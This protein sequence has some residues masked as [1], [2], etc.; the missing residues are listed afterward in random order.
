MITLH[1]NDTT[2]DINEDD[3]S[4]RYRALKSKPQLVLKFSLPKFIE[5]P[6]GTWCEYQNEKYYLKY[7][8]NLKKNGTR[9]IEYTMTMGTDVDNLSDYKMRNSVD[10]RLKWS[11]CAKPSEFIKEIVAE[12]NAKEGNGVWSVGECIDS[13]EKTVEFNHQYIFDALTSIAEAFSTEWEIVGHTISLHKVEYFKDDP[14]P[15]AYGKGNGFV[16][17]VGRATPSNEKP[18][19]RLYVQGGDRNID[20]SKYGSSELLLPKSQTYEYEGRTYKTDADGYYI[21]RNDKVS[22]Y[23]KEDSLDLSD[24]YPSRVG[25]VSS[26]EVKNAD[27]HFYDIID[28]TIPDSLNYS[29]C[30]IE[31]E[32]PT[33]IFQSGMLAGDG[34]EFEFT[35]NHKEKRFEIVPQEIDGITMPNETYKPVAGDKYAVFGIM[36]PDS[37]I[38]D[39]DTQSGA[40]WDMFK[41]GVKYLYE[42]EEQK[43]T[44]TGTLQGLWSKKNWLNIGGRMKVG[45]YILFKDDQFATEGVK[46]RITGIKDFT[47]KPYSPTIEIS[48]S[49]SGSSV[50]SSL[51]KIDATEVTI[52]DT[53]RDV[54]SFTKRRFR[55]ARETA[56]MLQDALLNYGAS[57]NPITVQTMQALVGD[58]SLQFDYIESVSKPSN[59]IGYPFRWDNENKQLTS[60]SCG[61][62]HYT[63]GVSD[64]TPTHENSEYKKWKLSALSSAKLTDATKRYYLYLKCPYNVTWD[65]NNIASANAEPILSE[66]AIG[67]QP[68]GENNYYFLAGIL[69]SEYEGERSFAPMNGFTEITPGQIVLDRILSKNGKSFWD[70]VNNAFHIGNDV[71]YLDFNTSNDGKLILNGTLVQR[72]GVQQPI[73]MYRGQWSSS[74]AYAV[75][76][77]VFYQDSDKKISSYICIKATTAGIAPTNTEYWEPFA[78]GVRGYQGYASFKSTAFIRLPDSVTSVN[79]PTGGNYS[80]PLPTSTVTY[81]GKTY[82]WSDGI[83]DGEYVL[84][85]TTRIF[86]TDASKQDAA[87]STPRKMTDTSEFDVCYHAASSLTPS[88]PTSHYTGTADSD[89]GNGWHNN[90]NTDDEWMAT[91]VKTNGEW[92]TWD[93]TKIKG[94]KGDSITGDTGSYYL[95]LYKLDTSTPSKPTYTNYPFVTTSS[96]WQTQAP[97]GVDSTHFIYMSYALLNPNTNTFGSWSTPIRISGANGE[98]GK[99]GSDIEFI[100]CRTSV[101]SCPSPSNAST[102]DD[103][104]PKESVTNSDLGWKDNPSGVTETYQYEFVSVRIKEK[105]AT[106]WG[107]FST[108]ALWSKWG[109]KGMDGD[110]VEYIFQRTEFNIKPSTP[111]STNTNGYVPNGW[112]N[113]PT[114]VDAS[115]PYEWVSIRRKSNE[116]WQSF[117]TPTLWRTYEHWNP[118]LL[119]QTEFENS[120]RMNKWETKSSYAG[121]GAD[122]S[123]THIV[124]G[125]I[126]GRNYYADINIKRSSES[127]YK[128]ILRQLL[129]NGNDVLKLQPATWYT[130]SFYE[131]CGA[132]SLFI[133]QTSSAYGFAQ[134]KLYLFAGHT[135]SLHIGGYVSQTAHDKGKYLAVFIYNSGWSKSWSVTTNETSIKEMTLTISDVPTTGEYFMQAYLYPNDDD[136][137]SVDYGTAT[138]SWVRLHDL[139]QQAAVYIYPSAV[140]TSTQGYIDGSKVSFGVDMQ[141]NIKGDQYNEGSD[142]QKWRQHIITFKTK[143]KSKNSDPDF[144]ANELLLFRLLPTAITGQKSF[145]QIC[146]PKLEVGKIATS[147]SPNTQDM[148][149][150]YQE[151]RFAKNGSTSTAPDLT[152]TASEPSGWSTVQPTLGKLEYLWMTVA[153]KYA[154]GT[155]LENWSDPVR[156]TPYDGTDGKSPAM[157]YRGIYDSAKLYYGTQYR[158]DVV[159]YQNT[160]YVARVDAGE[161]SAVTPT[162][163]TKWNT[164]GAQFESVATELLLAELANIAG[165][166]FKD[167]QLISQFG[168]IN[169]DET[170]EYDDDDF[171]PAIWLD[172]IHGEVHAGKSLRLDKDG[173][174]LF[175]SNGIMVAKIMNTTISNQIDTSPSNVSKTYANTTTDNSV[176]LPTSTYMYQNTAIVQQTVSLGYLYQNSTITI[177]AATMS[178]T[179]PTNIQGNSITYTTGYLRI[180]LWCGGRQIKQWQVSG[181]TAAAVSGTVTANTTLT[182]DGSTIPEGNYYIL[183]KIYRNYFSTG[184]GTSGGTSSKFSFSVSNAYYAY[185]RSVDK[186]FIIGNNG[187]FNRWSDTNYM[188]SSTTGHLF[189]YGNYVLRIMSSGIQKSTDGGSTWTSL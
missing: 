50:G 49:V 163:T 107:N 110:G 151:M 48:N 37:Y 31:G 101:N 150:E 40:S 18:I 116:V 7:P 127:S 160:Y 161:F 125:G 172:G 187:M 141:T 62:M 1:Y 95:F 117:S 139:T 185:R 11:M 164:F 51:N 78:Q 109:E 55:D 74:V 114:G 54:L 5:F 144:A 183:Y 128:E 89:Q 28:N 58:E 21:E 178:A 34:K 64:L 145:L 9:D 69:S 39:N 108:P 158:V 47:T 120:D 153:K 123:Y 169:G 72:G 104:V 84:W 186:K 112:T 17:G 79:A 44:F 23:T 60:D 30:I 174:S 88:N 132:S 182:V 76:D 16:P 22:D 71:N 45:S 162:S 82:S 103:Y 130:L 35:Y 46:I 137:S 157:V 70:M 15:L 134:Q 165:W 136:R 43:F 142:N 189:R 154:D 94:E 121:G 147:Y 155:L 99:D 156:V 8:E 122:D 36:L 184:G 173:I 59:V 100:Y 12:L 129:W 25:I 52:D 4:Y 29:D 53:K 111:S 19:K 176:Y 92:G 102:T 113:D 81:S 73:V 97:S 87:W 115:Y 175:D 93:I 179:F 83:P 138:W 24:T 6:V 67:M 177:N 91:C 77:V 180:E 140:D 188:L 143:S 171:V 170:S 33:I 90:A 119:E 68:S 166:I 148:R 41:E 10:H 124:Q 146:E 3:N 135:Y 14:L 63:L 65:S 56:E 96:G 168:T 118:N 20:R 2:L 66:T 105:G 149:T 98:T 181:G 167:N 57:I 80:S 27:K 38:C 152:K 75:N 32:T 106:S 13:V 26:V 131:R 42:N 86:S 61:I 133:S 159:K 85:A 126:D